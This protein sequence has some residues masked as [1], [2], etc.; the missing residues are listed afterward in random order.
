MIMATG[1]CLFADAEVLCIL[2]IRQTIKSGITA[3]AV[4]MRLIFIVFHLW[5]GGNGT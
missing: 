5:P 1:K 2:Q 3:R 4:V